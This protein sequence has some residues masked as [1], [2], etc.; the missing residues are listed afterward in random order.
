MSIAIGTA[1]FTLLVVAQPTAAAVKLS[2]FFWERAALEVV[3]RCNLHSPMYSKNGGWSSAAMTGR[4]PAARISTVN[5][6]TVNCKPILPPSLRT[7]Y[8][9][10]KNTQ[11]PDNQYQLQNNCNI[12]YTKPHKPTHKQITKSENPGKQSESR[13]NSTHLTLPQH[14]TLF[15]ELLGSFG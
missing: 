4:G 13:N 12:T 11:L 15:W 1:G 2:S 7:R 14:E 10:L 6:K 3:A 5:P 8:L 9:T